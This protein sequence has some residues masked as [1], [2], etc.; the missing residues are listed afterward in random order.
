MAAYFK[1]SAYG[2]LNRSS[3]DS[4]YNLYVNK[5]DLK[6]A[7]EAS[8]TSEHARH[9]PSKESYTLSIPMQVGAVMRR[10]WQILKG[11]WATQAVQVGFVFRRICFLGIFV[12]NEYR[13][14]IFQAIFTG[15]VFLQLA[16]DTTAYFSRGSLLFLYG[17]LMNP[18]C[19]R[20][21]YC[22]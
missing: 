6:V 9:A 20:T 2:Q 8:A 17:H 19:K 5:P 3:I 22:L 1:A 15:T 7:Y 16:N 13:S 18:N 4:Y 12:M 21:E 14:Q 10:R 11:D